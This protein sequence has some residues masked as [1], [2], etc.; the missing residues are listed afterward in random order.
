MTRRRGV[1]I[2]GVGMLCCAGCSAPTSYTTS[3]DLRVN[4]ALKLLNDSNSRIDVGAF[5]GIVD[6]VPIPVLDFRDRLSVD[7]ASGWV[8]HV[9]AQ[10]GQSWSLGEVRI[11][12]HPNG[13]STISTATRA[14]Q[15]EQD[16]L[17]IVLQATEAEIDRLSEPGALLEVLNRPITGASYNRSAEERIMLWRATLT[18]AIE[19]ARHGD[20]SAVS[21]CTSTTAVIHG[22]V[23]IEDPRGHLVDAS[24]I[25]KDLQEKSLGIIAPD[26]VAGATSD[27]ATEYSWLLAGE[28]VVEAVCQEVGIV[29]ATP[30]P[31]IDFR[32]GRSL[33][34]VLPRP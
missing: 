5:Y 15:A 21:L 31:R 20:G 25:G 32:L 11:T 19:D 28:P 27:S 13:C 6:G 2:W 8:R 4:H 17:P 14:C 22:R 34:I 30:Y 23:V 10:A 29:N 26:V 9:A 1:L 18:A 33:R 3:A 12:R 16:V 24:Q 7:E